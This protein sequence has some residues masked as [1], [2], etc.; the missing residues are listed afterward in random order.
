MLATAPP[1][2]PRRGWDAKDH[3]SSSVS[4]S[5]LTD[6]HKADKLSGMDSTQI[7]TIEP[8][9]RSGQPCIRGCALPCG[10]SWSTSPAG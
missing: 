3:L 1:Y 9:K 2:P 10:T 4:H 6:M 8:G 7:I 5:A